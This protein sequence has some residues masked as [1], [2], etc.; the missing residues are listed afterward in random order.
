MS[1]E[2][3]RGATGGGLLTPNERFFVRNNLPRPADS[4]LHDRDAWTLEI[5][6]VVHP[7][8]LSLGELKTLGLATE[9][10]TLQC[11][12]NGRAFF[13]HRPSGSPWATGA[14][15]CA[16]WTGVRLR[17]VLEFMGGLDETSKYLTSTGGEPLPAG[18]AR[19]TVVVERSIPIE[20]ALRDALLAWE[21]NSLPIPITHGG[22]L[23]LIVPGYFGINHIKYV[24]RIAATLEQ[25][26]AKIQ[27]KGYRFRAIGTGGAPTQ[28]SMW[29]M[30]V[31]SWLNGPGTSGSTVA[32]GRTVFHG[33]AL[34]GERGV[35]RV[36]VSLDG[37]AHWTDATFDGPDLG[38]NAWRAFS[39]VTDLSIGSHTVHTRATDTVGDV[40]S[41]D[42][43]ENERGYGHNGWWDHGLE[44]TV[45][46]VAEPQPT[47]ALGSPEPPPEAPV[48]LSDAGTRGKALFRDGPQPACG[49]CH[50][51]GDAGTTGVVGP[52]LDVLAPD[53]ARVESAVTAGVGAMPA[54]G[55]RLT[56]TEIRDL[57]AYVAEATQR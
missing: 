47:D 4:V 54:Y 52:N 19:D 11:S 32:A 21:M 18:V 48:V 53:A 57:A 55:E 45:T 20:K 30:P 17:D 39:F 38:P 3:R 15:G 23:R 42:R 28:P 34:S 1:L 44:I 33:V 7:G 12:G 41:R 40:Q 10:V 22:P 49:T 6:G 51:L 5:A 24:R 9:A 27:Q 37:G 16:L 56:D 2:T 50:T 43:V 36:E 29:R 25:T 26:T 13:A 35:S 46:A 8:T 14:A 31:K